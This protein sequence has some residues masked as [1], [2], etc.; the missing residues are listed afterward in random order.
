M[1][2]PIVDLLGSVVVVAMQVEI[3]FG[4]AA[5]AGLRCLLHSLEF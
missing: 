5:A 1:R 3:D 4:P 2:L